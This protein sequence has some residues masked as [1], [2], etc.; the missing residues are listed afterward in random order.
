MIKK[1]AC[2]FV[3]LAVPVGLYGAAA[4]KK[5]AAIQNG[6]NV[7]ARVSAT[8]VYSSQCY[9]AYYGCMDQFCIS[10][11]VNGGS[12]LCS[13]DN[14]KYEQE[15][16]EIGEMLARADQIKTVEVEKIKLGANADIVFSGGRQYDAN[17]NVVFKTNTTDPAQEKQTRQAK[18]QDLLKM[19][20]LKF[21]DEEDEEDDNI[22]NKT[23]AALFAAA[24]ATCSAQVGDDCAKDMKLLRQIYQRQ[25][26][27]DC[28][29]FANSI[30]QQ[31]AAATAA[32]NDA[33]AAVRNALK[34]S[35]AAANKYN[36]GECM[37]EFKK[38]MQGPDAC[39]ADWANCVSNVASENMQNNETVHT[40]GTK[41][42][43]T[44]KFNISAS[45]MERLDAKR[46]ICERVLDQC[47]AV[48]DTVWDAFL[49]E[50]GPT[51]RAAELR[52]ESDMR[53]SCLTNITKCIH[54]ACQD[55][56]AAK[57]VAT[58]DSC[59]TRPEMAR[60]FCKIE[61]DPCERMAGKQLWDYVTDKLL[62]MR[63]DSC[64]NSV[65]S[66]FMDENR[67]GPDFMNC[68]GMDYEFIRG[69]CPLDS[70]VACKTYDTDNNGKFDMDDLDSIITGLYLNID[71]KAL[72]NCQNLV[73]KKMMEICGST[74][75]C[76]KFASDDTIGTG[77]L[78]YQKIGGVHRVSGM[79]SFGKINVGSDD[80]TA[81]L[82]DTADYAWWLLESG[83]VTTNNIDFADTVIYELD[84]I[85][86]TINRVITMIE[87]DPKIQYCV[88]GRNLEQITGEKNST[89][90]RFPNLLNQIKMQIAVAALRQAQNNYQA[91]YNEY[92]SKATQAASTDM[93]NLMCNKLPFSDGTAQ[94]MSAADLKTDILPPGQLVVE[95]GGVSNAALAAGGTHTSASVG[96]TVSV[97]HKSG[98][99]AGGNDGGAL[100]TVG[101][102]LTT[103][104][105][106][107]GHILLQRAAEKAATQIASG[108]TSKALESLVQSAA[109]FNPATLAVTAIA[110]MSTKAIGIL[111]SDHYKAEWDGGSR[112]MWT[113]FN[114]DTRVCR[115][116]TLTVT[117]DCKSAYKHGFMGI[118]RK[119]EQDCV[120]SEPIEKCQDIEM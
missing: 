96:G 11:N 5:Q 34:D 16:A 1:I 95:F 86:G 28:R 69:I 49:R 19:F 92:I 114:R 50:S 55:D 6:T 13:N 80:K 111:A 93:A 62:A 71:N 100:S 119:N 37:V 48:R 103:L 116:C 85:Q 81:G 4:V 33:D 87:S 91:K 65:K 76:N 38:C 31:K 115:L 41:V 8:G 108:V 66:C 102:T 12:C 118:G 14:A 64:T 97:E 2:A 36:Q 35:F 54:T 3:L 30:A 17:G 44:V 27:S 106:Q 18:R 9:D 75:D 56:I 51:L 117:K 113:T 43:T 23:G 77:S 60:S 105:A 58:M 42:A 112:E 40:Y 7:R 39:G 53:Q 94:G 78:Q 46:T 70:L 47:M 90:A 25:I 26:D 104:G 73:E 109:S 15:L 72:E 84:N 79:I 67:C 99:A 45:V 29:G 63:V 52:A 82:I 88:T 74:T 120:T 107:A 89:T 32:L 61:I 20:E 21:E 24:N 98:N 10:D 59:L 83:K 68:I 22:M 110:D 101:G 57:G